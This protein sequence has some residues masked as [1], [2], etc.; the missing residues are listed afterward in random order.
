MRRTPES[1]AAAGEGPSLIENLDDQFLRDA[2]VDNRNRMTGAN[3]PSTQPPVDPGCVPCDA[4]ASVHSVFVHCAGCSRVVRS[5]V[6][7]ISFACMYIHHHVSIVPL[8]RAV[9]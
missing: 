3:S 5:N 6:R 2:L 7:C 1:L 9:G 8:H 4:G